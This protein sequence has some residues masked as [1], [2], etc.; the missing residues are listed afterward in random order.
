[1][2]DDPVRVVA[3]DVFPGWGQRGGAV[4]A[5]GEVGRK[6]GPDF[7]GAEELGPVRKRAGYRGVGEDDVDQVRKDQ[8]PEE[9]DRAQEEEQRE[10]AG[11]AQSVGENNQSLKPTL[12]GN[13]EW[14]KVNAERKTSQRRRSKDK[15]Q[16]G[17]VTRSSPIQLQL[18][19]H[20]QVP[21]LPFSS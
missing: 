18:L 7:G 3:E 15:S 5:G 17:I 6:E 8:R 14:R 21:S 11:H 19:S 10:Q 13:R 4:Q 9:G 12:D 1:M 2:G 16:W 20:S